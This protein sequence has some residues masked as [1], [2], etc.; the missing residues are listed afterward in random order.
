MASSLHGY[1]LNPTVVIAPVRMYK[2][3]VTEWLL[4]S[5]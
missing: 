5:T 4:D 1:I 2:G 3:Q